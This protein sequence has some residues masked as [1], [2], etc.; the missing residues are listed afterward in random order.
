LMF[1][2]LIPTRRHAELAKHLARSGYA[3][4]AMGTPRQIL[5]D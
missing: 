4:R 5:S 1:H 3:Y 2:Y